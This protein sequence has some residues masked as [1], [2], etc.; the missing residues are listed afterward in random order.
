[1]ERNSVVAEQDKKEISGTVKDTQGAPLFGV[2]VAVKGTSSG[3]ITDVD[4]KFKLSIPTSA[5]IL[6]FSFVGMKTKEVSCEEQTTFNIVMEEESISLGEVVAIGYGTVRKPDLTGSVGV[7]SVEDMAK[8]PVASFDEA[9]AGRV[10]GVQVTATDGQPGAAINIVI[11]GNG[12]LTQST[13]PLYVIDG[14]PVEDPD[15]K[16]LNPEEIKSMTI[17]KDA[18]STA[19]YGSRGANGVILIETKRGQVGRP[20]VT[21]SSSTGIQMAPSKIELMS[22]YEFVK[23]QQELHPTSNT[24]AYYF[25]DD[26]DLDYYKGMAGLDL[27]DHLFQQGITQIY[28]LAMRGGTKSTRYSI[29]G[30]YYDQKGTII[31]T[32]LNRYSGRVTID[33]EISNKIKTGVTVNYAVSEQQGQV[34]NEGQYSNAN[35]TSF[36]LS[37]AWMYRPVDFYPDTDLLTSLYDEAAVTTSDIRINPYISQKN[38]YSFRTTKLLEAN[39]YISYDIIKDLTFKSTF[40]TRQNT[41]INEAFYNS[42]TAQASP[43]NLNNQNGI[44]GL[45]RTTSRNQ[46]NISNTLTYKKT[47]NKNHTIT[48][49]A[50][51]EASKLHTNIHGY[52]GK[53]LPN[54]NLGMDGL[55]E[56]VAYNPAFSNSENKLASYAFR[57]D[58]NYKSMYILTGTFRADGSSKFPNN[59]G[60]F[61]SMAAAWNMHKEEF[62][63]NALPWISTSKLRFGYGSTGNNRIGDFDYSSSLSFDLVSH[64][65]SFNNAMAEGGAYVSN[66]GNAGLKWET[67]KTIDLGY[68]LGLLE[69]RI[70]FEFEIYRKTTEDLLLRADLPPTTGFSKAVK[71]IGRLK[72]EGLEISVNTTNVS[73][74]SFTWQSNFNISFNKNSVL[75][76]TNG[77]RNLPSTVSYVSQFGQPLYL[78]EI[79]RSSGMMIGYIWEGNYQYEDFEN[80]APGV[81]I[82]KPDVP[83]NGSTRSSIQ[84]GDIKY[85]DLN[86]DG[87]MNNADVTFIGRGNPK[88]IGG[89][90]NNLSYRNF[91]LNIFFQW[92]YGNDV[93]NANRLL[94][95]GNS[96]KYALINQYASYVNRWTP[97]NATNE[98]YRA[99]GQGPIGYHSSRVVEDGSFVRLKT[100]NLSYSIPERFIRKAYLSQLSINIS[101][102]NLVTWTNYTGLDPEVSTRGNLLTPGYDYSSYPKSP[103]IL[104][105]IK[106]AF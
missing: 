35:P 48:G 32:G 95:E 66:V 29:S 56:G 4:G 40:G 104:F 9:L 41:F 11:R 21:F 96:N 77:Q 58:Y 18:S 51:F 28:D 19:I 67:V 72:N 89:F 64:G 90:T 102:Q 76:L 6:A 99:G 16:T 46:F 23:Y 87:T 69:N 27:Q 75:A 79:G 31:N 8:A 59:W 70:M 100:V 5:K 85:R 88:H 78:A 26:K 10:A 105:G 38:Q 50:L 30:S 103:A 39:G 54:E 1:M 33:Q 63:A 86:G 53:N 7:A 98:N 97:E 73:T 94:L 80:P 57:A 34:I 68:E 74:V 106:G 43:A 42:N 2:T 93:Y 13:S 83:G 20:V 44:F 62:F 52:G 17:L 65:Y 82:L 61:P 37:S 92:S 84:P 22:P 49:L 81:Y 36:V 25:L 45:I 55:N 15:P 3:T 12:S 47:I 60:Y 71:N 101:A 91:D 24:T 14:F